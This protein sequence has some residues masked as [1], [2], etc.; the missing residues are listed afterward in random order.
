MT[1]LTTEQINYMNTLVE[2]C[3]TLHTDWSLKQMVDYVVE[4][5]DV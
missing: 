2:V 5:M 4:N 1:I 3:Q